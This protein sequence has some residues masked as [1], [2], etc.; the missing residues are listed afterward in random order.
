MVGCHGVDELLG[1]VAGTDL[2][3]HRDA[4]FIGE[5][6]GGGEPAPA[7]PFFDGVFLHGLAHGGAVVG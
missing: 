5:G 3:A 6:L 1:G 2:G 7:G 4:L